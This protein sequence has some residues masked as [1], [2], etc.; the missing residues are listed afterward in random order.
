MASPALPTTIT[1]QRL[2]T[3]RDLIV[4]PAEQIE[5]D[6]LQNALIAELN[7][8]GAIEALTFQDLFHA[9][10]TL[11]RLRRLEA[12][13]DPSDEKASDRLTRRQRSAQ[14][15]YYTALKELRTLQ[16]NRAL[17]A[18]KLEDPADPDIPA[19]TDI[20]QFTKQTHSEV[21]AEGIKQAV[22][23]LDLQS[24]MFLRDSR[25]KRQP[26]TASAPVK[27]DRAL[28]L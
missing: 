18:S 10:W 4:L 12:E 28:R 11:R 5:F 14:R 13:C 17:R 8:Q 21:T 7:P 24:G 15:A 6:C 25:E 27:D 22:R 19:I 20:N 1:L 26:S 23:L 16:T 2:L 3:S 9:A